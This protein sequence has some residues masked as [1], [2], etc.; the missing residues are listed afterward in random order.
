MAKPKVTVLM[1]VYN[2]RDFLAEAIQS[3]LDQ[4]YGDFEFLIIDDGSTEPLDPILQHYKDKRIV[5]RRQENMGLTRSLNK[6]LSLARGDYIARMDADDVS[7]RN[8]LELEVRELDSDMCID[9]VGCFFDVVDGEGCLI[10]TKELITDPIYRLWRLQFH[11][12]YG[13]GTM[14]LRKTSVL[15]AGSYDE[16]LSYSQDYDLWSRLSTKNN[17]VIVPEVMYRYRMV[18]D[19][20]QASVKNYDTQL[21][22]A[23]RVSDRNLMACDD[24]LSVEDC[25]EL[26]ALYLKL[27]CGGISVR[28]V[29]FLPDLLEG[30]CGRFKITNEER[31]RL[32]QRIALDV[33]TDAEKSED[34]SQDEKKRIV[35][36]ALSFA[37]EDLPFGEPHRPM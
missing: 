34:L 32:C 17:T 23:L 18:D 13:H 20:A 35:E 15:K 28:A 12:N 4:S 22:N 36:K 21:T 27:G 7:L 1:S 30:F 37:G 11:N 33:I 2:G 19:G 10:E 16:N 6:G 3:V 31:S 26:R 29:E 24:R 8:R 14:M 9:L 25:R 5:L